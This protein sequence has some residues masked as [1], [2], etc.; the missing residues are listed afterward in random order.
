MQLYI[1]AWSSPPTHLMNHCAKNWYKIL[2]KYLWK[3]HGQTR[4]WETYIENWNK[5]P[6]WRQDLWPHHYVFLLKCE[7]A[8]FS[9]NP[10][11]SCKLTFQQKYKVMW[12]QILPPAINDLAGSESSTRKFDQIAVFDAVEKAKYLGEIKYVTVSC[13]SS[14]WAHWLSPSNVATVGKGWIYRGLEL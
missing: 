2:Q 13:L 6:N 11:F 7:F 3:K 8:F 1:W 10:A 5:V 4:L 12:W 14:I 9:T